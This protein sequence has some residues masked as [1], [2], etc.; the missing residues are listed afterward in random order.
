[1]NLLAPMEIDPV[2]YISFAFVFA[3]FFC[4]VGILEG[5]R[6]R[7]KKYMTEFLVFSVVVMGVLIY[8]SFVR[9]FV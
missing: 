5:W 7:N 3:F 9:W 1:M 6:K 8:I 4:F 2:I